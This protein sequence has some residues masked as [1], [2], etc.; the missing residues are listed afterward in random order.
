MTLRTSDMTWVNNRYI[1]V[2]PSERYGHTA[3]PIG[4]HLIIMGGWDGGKP[5]ADV[6]VLRDRSVA[7]RADQATMF[8]RPADGED[9]GD[10][11][12]VAGE[13]FDDEGAY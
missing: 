13:F 3:T 10:P 7:D 11:E 8:D 1:G 5:L 6:V 4:P 2:P 9:F 12:E